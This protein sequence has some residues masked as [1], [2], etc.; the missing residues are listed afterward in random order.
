MRPCSWLS[1]EVANAQESSIVIGRPPGCPYYLCTH[2]VVMERPRHNDFREAKLTS[3]STVGELA[4]SQ[5][6]VLPKQ[7][8]ARGGQLC[9]SLARSPSEWMSIKMR[10]PL[11]TSPKNTTLRLSPASGQP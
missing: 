10:L 5:S 3:G 1:G 8:H 11:P 9:Y 7:T 2:D 6:H 4:V